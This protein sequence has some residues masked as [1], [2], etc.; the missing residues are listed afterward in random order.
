MRALSFSVLALIL[1]TACGNTDRPLRDLRS[2][3]GGPDEF[4][5]IPLGPLEIP[6]T[7]DLPP[8]TPGGTNR[9][10]PS[11]N[12]DAIRALGGSPSAQIAGG[13]PA[14]DAALVA[15]TNRYGVDPNIRAVLAAEDE[16]KLDR[17][18]RSNFFNPLG[19]D[20]YFPAYR[21]QAL[22]A[23]AERAR[24]QAAGVTVAEIPAEVI[25]ER[26]AA[27]AT[28]FERLGLREGCVFTTAGSPDGRMRRVCE[29]DETNVEQASGAEGSAEATEPARTPFLERI[30]L[31]DN[32]VITTAGSPDGRF[33]RVCDEDETE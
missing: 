1:V 19:R 24:L 16:A 5:V 32:C 2:A 27:N 15:Q 11:P 31:G 3:G 12:A 22:D 18:R 26:D 25:E 21:R 30:G 9:T 33:R 13:I 14:G 28:F 29:G 10:D 6:Q 20:R 23:S 8:P 7:R 17:A 4:A